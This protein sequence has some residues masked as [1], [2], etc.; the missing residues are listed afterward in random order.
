M[1]SHHFSSLKE[2]SFQEVCSI[3]EPTKS[4][5]INED[6]S[7]NCDFFLMELCKHFNC[8]IL[9]FNDNGEHLINAFARYN[10]HPRITSIYNSTY[11]T[12]DI[13]DDVIAQ[14][15]LDNF[16]K[17]KFNVF[18]SGTASERDYY[19]YDLIVN[20]KALSSGCS[21]EIDGIVEIIARNSVLKQ[22]KYKITLQRI[23]YYE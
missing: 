10:V 17:A 13:N 21:R 16:E 6:I 18:R 14:R 15:L 11:V 1:L 19:E 20:I 5:L 7:Q 3:L 9:Q 22:V 2:I 12:A 4:V 23:I 8:S